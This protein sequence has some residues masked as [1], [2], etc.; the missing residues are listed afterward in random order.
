MN[1]HR[2]AYGLM[3]V[4]KSVSLDSLILTGPGQESIQTCK[5]KI[6]LRKK[7]N[8]K[9]QKHRGTDLFHSW[10]FFQRSDLER[11][12]SVKVVCSPGAVRAVILNILVR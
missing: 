1:V 5:N 8:E 12:L 10:N 6:Q 2:K 4:Y 11:N 3:Q 9:G 7:N